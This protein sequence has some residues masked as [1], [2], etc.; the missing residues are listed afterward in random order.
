MRVLLLCCACALLAAAQKYSGPRPAKTDVPYLVHADSLAETESTEAKEQKKK[1]DI[2]YV[3]AGANSP[4]RTPLASPVF[5]VQAQKLDVNALQLFKLEP[6][7][8]ER[9]ILFRNKK[10]GNPRPIRMDVKP[11]GS[12]LFRM[13]VDESLAPGEYSLT[14][15]GSNQVFCFQVY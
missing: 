2:L 11:L 15:Q 13:E 3:I 9:E 6:R 10:S 14:P 12:G 1:D 4:A 5:L 7:N 8:G